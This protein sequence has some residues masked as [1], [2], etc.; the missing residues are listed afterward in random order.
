MDA[1][2]FLTIA[3]AS[4]LLAPSPA[5]ATVPAK[6]TM[7]AMTVTNGL[8]NQFFTLI[9]PGLLLCRRSH[10][11]TRNKC[12]KRPNHRLRVPVGEAIEARDQWRIRAHGTIN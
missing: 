7:A 6:T 4:S 9:S 2:A 5:T 10:D 3:T 11:R 1:T 8:L 12:H